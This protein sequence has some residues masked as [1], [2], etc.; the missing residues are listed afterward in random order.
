M[1]KKK[2]T[3]GDQEKELTV[4]ENQEFVDMRTATGHWPSPS[5]TEE[6]LQ[7]LAAQG[8]I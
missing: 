1:S 3:E 8:L 7:E 6:E 4:I 5:M 2:A